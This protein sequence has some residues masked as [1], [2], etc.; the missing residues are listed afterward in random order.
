MC[1]P[2]AHSRAQPA[3]AEAAAVA[4]SS[5][6]E[7]ESSCVAWLQQLKLK[8][9]RHLQNAKQKKKR[10]EAAEKIKINNILYGWKIAK[11]NAATTQT[12]T[13]AAA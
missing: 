13:A 2:V 10:E 12:T 6:A 8:F 11:K 1:V 4:C 3:E 9:A 5:I 7:V